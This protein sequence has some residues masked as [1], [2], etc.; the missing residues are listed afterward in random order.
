VAEVSIRAQVIIG[1]DAIFQND[2]GLE[3]L[4]YDERD[5]LQ[6]RIGD[7]LADALASMDLPE[8]WKFSEGFKL[9]TLAKPYPPS[10]VERH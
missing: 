4:T 2:G 8:G 9:T 6:D 1:G 3:E 10:E 5:A 7:A